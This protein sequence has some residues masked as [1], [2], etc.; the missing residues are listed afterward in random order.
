LWIAVLIFLLLFIKIGKGL[1]NDSLLTLIQVLLFVNV[2]TGF[3]FSKDGSVFSGMFY[4]NAVIAFQK[5]ILSIAVFL[6]SL[7]C[8]D[9]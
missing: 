8:A 9:W 1:K 4:T 3:L 7:L 5:N 6:I 2:V